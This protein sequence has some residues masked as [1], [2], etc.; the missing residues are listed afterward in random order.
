MW[1]MEDGIKE[2]GERV[3]LRLQGASAAALDLVGALGDVAEEPAD[4]LPDL[5]LSAE[6]FIRGDLLADPAPDGPVGV[7]DR[8]VGGRAHQA[9]IDVGCDQI[10]PQGIAAVCRTVVPHDD[11]KFGM[12]GAHKLHCLNL[13]GLQTDGRVVAGLLAVARD[14]RADQGRFALVHRSGA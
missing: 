14:G 4:V 12:V 2:G 6:A 7:E 8:A 10:G 5:R 3:D 13:A 1:L 9:E 11:Q